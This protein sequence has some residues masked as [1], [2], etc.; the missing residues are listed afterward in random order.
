MMLPDFPTV[1]AVDSLRPVTWDCLD[2]TIDV[3]RS[4]SDLLR[5]ST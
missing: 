2:I 4:L 3:F 5:R 1:V